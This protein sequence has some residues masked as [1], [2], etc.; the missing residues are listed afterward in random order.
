MQL[1]SVIAQSRTARFAPPRNLRG[2][3]HVYDDGIRTAP[4]NVET[5]RVTGGGQ[6]E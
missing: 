3:E 2:P 4:S 6:P 5:V 1:A